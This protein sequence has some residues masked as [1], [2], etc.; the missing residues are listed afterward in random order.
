MIRSLESIEF[1]TSEITIEPT[2][3]LLLMKQEVNDNYPAIYSP[4]M[5][6]ASRAEPL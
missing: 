2:T 1:Q 4:D 6:V 3:L 5:V